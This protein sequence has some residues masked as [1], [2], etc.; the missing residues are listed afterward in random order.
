MDKEFNRSKEQIIEKMEQ[1]FKA[2]REALDEK[3]HLIVNLITVNLA[4][5]IAFI[6]FLEVIVKTN[7][8]QRILLHAEL[9]FLS[10]SL[11]LGSMQ[12]N[13]FYQIKNKA[14]KELSQ[15]SIEWLRNEIKNTTVTIAESRIQKIIDKIYF[16]TFILSILILVTLAFYRL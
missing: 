10:F 9:G 13:Y 2:K 7:D 3:R 15:K 11:I 5:L 12:L 14:A 1:I 16:P 8:L 6:G 4:L